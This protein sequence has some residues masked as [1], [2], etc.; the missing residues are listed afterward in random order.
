MRKT[1]QL[2]WLSIAAV[3]SSF[4][5]L[6]PA[7]NA[8]TSKSSTQLRKEKAALNTATTKLRQERDAFQTQVLEKNKLISIA[9]AGV[10]EVEDALNDLEKLVEEQ[11]EDSDE[12]EYFLL[13]A[14][15]AVDSAKLENQKLKETHEALSLRVQDLAVQTYIGRD[16]TVEGSFG[17]ATTGDIYKAAR[18]QTII[19]AAFG[20]IK[21]TGDKVRALRIDMNQATVG[22]QIAKDKQQAK[23]EEADQQLDELFEALLL[24][25]QMVSS[26]KSKLAQRLSEG[27]LV[28][29]AD[30][31]L[32]AKIKD[33][34]RKVAEVIRA[35]KAARAREERIVR[36]AE[37]AARRAALGVAPMPTSN[38][39]KLS[40][41]TTVWGIRVHESIAGNLLKLLQH[42]LRDG[43][44]FGGG[45]YRGA[46]S[47]IALRK[48]H[49]GT[50]QWSI[51][52]KPSYQCRP[53]TARPGS[54]MHERG[55]A[56]DFTQNGRALWSSTS[57]Y[58]WLRR[59]A[60]Q[61]GFKNLPSEPWHWSTSGR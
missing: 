48:A 51:Y 50:S 15:A 30:A 56:I 31:Q 9:T 60:R 6:T 2:V 20:D 8:A 36:E 22:L 40:E 54:S 33:S 27:A 26:A 42:A 39:I 38:N 47:Q 12:A 5:W 29:D 19:G 57:G 45:G 34:E 14:E 24:Q 49:C 44:R 61:Y 46:A 23:Q 52:K 11:R 7:V 17:L 41:L 3:L 25:D 32:A 53:P 16:S 35:E 1:I 4:M 55:L 28:D 58:K 59:N 13:A 43:I 37:E 21:N 10:S 18:I